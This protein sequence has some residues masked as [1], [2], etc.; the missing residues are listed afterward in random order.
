MG[1]GRGPARTCDCSCPAIGRRHLNG[2]SNKGALLAETDRSGGML[3]LVYDTKIA[4]RTQ[5]KRANE[6]RTKIPI[7]GY[8]L[9]LFD[10]SERVHICR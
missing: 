1:D 6:P 9:R 4:G 5:G 10:A 3:W 7:G 8:D 2:S